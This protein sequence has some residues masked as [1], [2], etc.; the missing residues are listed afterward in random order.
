M[1][2]QIK[3]TYLFLIFDR[4]KIG[5]RDIRVVGPDYADPLK[6]FRHQVPILKM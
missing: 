3:T 6:E 4:K 5:F 1:N 2:T